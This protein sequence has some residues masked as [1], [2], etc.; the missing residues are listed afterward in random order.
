LLPKPLSQMCISRA[1]FKTS[2]NKYRHRLLYAVDW[3][4]L[5]FSFSIDLV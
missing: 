1:L 2:I 4:S 3:F 5:V